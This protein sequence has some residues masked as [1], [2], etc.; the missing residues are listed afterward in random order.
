MI[1]HIVMLNLREDARHDDLM[2]VMTGLGELS[3]SLSGFASFEHGPNRD[4]ETKSDCYPYG[5]MCTFDNEAALKAYAANESHKALG[6]R[7][8][9]MCE[10]GGDG[11]FVVDL[12]I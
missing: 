10:G 3:Q 1:R 5:F 9:A 8:V 6:A 12:E 4:F 2:D 11:I 7:L